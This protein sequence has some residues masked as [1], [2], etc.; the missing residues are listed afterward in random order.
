MAAVA[1]GDRTI[2]EKVLRHKSPISQLERRYRQS[3]MERL[4]AGLKESIDTSSIHLA[5]LAATEALARHAPAVA[6]RPGNERI[7]DRVTIRAFAANQLPCAGGESHLD[8][9]ALYVVTAL[10]VLSQIDVL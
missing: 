1:S 8:D 4:H 10:W 5:A 6:R 3:H 2:A 7:T 9:F